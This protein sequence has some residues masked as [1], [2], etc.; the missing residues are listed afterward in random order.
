MRQ[1][2]DEYGFIEIF[3]YF[4]VHS[5]IQRFCEIPG[6]YWTIPS[7][8]CMYFFFVRSIIQFINWSYTFPSKEIEKHY[9]I[10]GESKIRTCKRKRRD[11]PGGTGK[12][13]EEPGGTGRNR[14]EPGNRRRRR[15]RRW[16]GT[17]PL[18]DWLSSSFCLIVIVI[19]VFQWI[20][21]SIFFLF[22]RF[23]CKCPTRSNTRTLFC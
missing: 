22:K 15:S 16:K 19:E 8:F 2:S 5:F 4:K 6:D 10:H 17:D 3:R 13:R 1:L 23:T 12:N 7:N 18:L 9:F 21:S 11:E 14:E 20:F